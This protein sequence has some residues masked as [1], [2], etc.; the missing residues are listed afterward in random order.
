[1][2]LVLTI[3]LLAAGPECYFVSN[4]RIHLLPSCDIDPATIDALTEEPTPPSAATA[5]QRAAAPWSRRPGPP[6]A[7]QP[8]IVVRGNE[9]LEQRLASA[10]QQRID[11]VSARLTAEEELRIARQ[12][13]DEALRDLASARAELASLQHR[14]RDTG[15]S[16][17][18]A[19]ADGR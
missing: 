15:G 9:E 1:V 2:N 11:A 10:E 17:E 8:R 16:G 18:N 4:T 5:R 7:A 19:T 3:A 13:R 6:R 14:C 12:Q